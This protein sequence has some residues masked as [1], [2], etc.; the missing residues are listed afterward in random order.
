[1]VEETRLI[2]GEARIIADFAAK[3]PLKEGEAVTF[4][5][6]EGLRGIRP[7]SIDGNAGSGFSSSK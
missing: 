6:V 7:D 5:D 3:R 4:D 1:M 2:G